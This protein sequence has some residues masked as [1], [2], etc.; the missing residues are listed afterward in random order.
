MVLITPNTENDRNVL[1][2]KDIEPSI[3][4]CIFQRKIDTFN[5][6]I[7]FFTSNGLVEISL[8]QLQKCIET[9]SS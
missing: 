1:S 4:F 3:G 2:I 9:V 5:R 6:Y 7:V 8:Q